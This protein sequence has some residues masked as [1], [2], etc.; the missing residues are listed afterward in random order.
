[1]QLA[2]ENKIDFLETSAKLGTNIEEIFN[3]LNAKILERIDK[4]QLDIT[5]HPGIKI[6]SEKYNGVVLEK[7]DAT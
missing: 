5:S 1:M 2:R 3:K 7:Q 6:G 4:G